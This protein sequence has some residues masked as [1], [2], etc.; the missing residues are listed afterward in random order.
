MATTKIEC[1]LKRPG[2]TTVTL[3]GRTYKFE[4]DKDGRHV[5]EVSNSDDAKRLLAIKEA[6]RPYNPKDAAP[7]RLT[8][9]QKAEETER[10]ALVQQYLEKFS[11]EP[12]DDMTT[13]QLRE[14]I[15]N[16]T[17]AA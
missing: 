10:N 11:V 12:P 3:N 2:G 14:A 6:Y 17:G 1:I 5:C 4:P 8:A 16:G 15:E 13:E 7:A 9:Q